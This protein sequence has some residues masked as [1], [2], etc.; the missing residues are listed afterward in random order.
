MTKTEISIT[1]VNVQMVT[2]KKT[3]SVSHVII[4]VPN[5]L[6]MMY[7]QNVQMSTEFLNFVIV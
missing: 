3:E 1:I 5:V 6:G 4:N 7:A 2:T